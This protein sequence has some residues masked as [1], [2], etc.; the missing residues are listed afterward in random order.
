[1]NLDLIKDLSKQIALSR[2]VD[3]L[4]L[5]F[6]GAIAN[7][8]QGSYTDPCRLRYRHPHTTLLA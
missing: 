8:N 6:V 5:H 3:F 4:P 2:K 1:M 7:G